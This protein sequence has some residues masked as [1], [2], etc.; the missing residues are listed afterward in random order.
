MPV[1]IV[2]SK[3]K[4]ISRSTRF[5][6]PWCNHPRLSEPI[7]LAKMSYQLS[8]GREISK[9]RKVPLLTT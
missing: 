5:A 6:M 1:T 9:G 8:P 2:L 3:L 4:P 7:A